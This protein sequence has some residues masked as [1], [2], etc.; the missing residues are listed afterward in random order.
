[1]AE[2]TDIISFL[3]EAKKLLLAG[4]L[5]FVPRK[6]NLEDM[7]RLGLTVSDLEEELAELQPLHYF[8]GPKQDLKRKGF[9][10]EF[11]K[12]VEGWPF[13]I[14]LKIDGGW[15]KCLGFHL[16]AFSMEVRR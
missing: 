5:D 6:K 3:S 16:D 13:Y 8:K 1:M 10:W 11:K 12:L 14:K 2:R 4:Q 7:A 15:L 9:I